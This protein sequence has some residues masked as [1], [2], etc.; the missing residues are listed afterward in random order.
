[1]ITK[2]IPFTE[3]LKFINESVHVVYSIPIDPD[4]WGDMYNGDF[5]DIAIKKTGDRIF[6]TISNN[7]ITHVE[8][9]LDEDKKWKIFIKANPFDEEQVREAD[10][11]TAKSVAMAE[12]LRQHYKGLEA[13]AINK[14]FIDMFSH[15]SPIMH[16]YT[17]IDNSK[18]DEARG[19]KKF[20]VRADYKFRTDNIR[21]KKK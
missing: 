8:L 18:T 13:K 21:V 2:Y 6:A 11:I 10:R 1:M 16:Q 5:R 7:D 3:A 4:W 9:K 17:N 19:L 12:G 15:E 14:T 20:Q